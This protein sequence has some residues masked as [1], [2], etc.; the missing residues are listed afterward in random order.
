M[1]SEDKKL[2]EGIF[3]GIKNVINEINNFFDDAKKYQQQFDAIKHTG[4]GKKSEEELDLMLQICNGINKQAKSKYMKKL[5]EKFMVELEMQK[6]EAQG[7]L[8]EG[9]TGPTQLKKINKTIR[10]IAFIC[11][12]VLW[13]AFNATIAFVVVIIFAVCAGIYVSKIEAKNKR[14][15]EE[16]QTDIKDLITVAGVGQVETVKLL[17][18]KG[19]DIEA[20]SNDGLTALICAA[21]AGQVE[22]VKLL[23]DRGADIEAKNNDGL[24]VLMCAASMGQT[25]TVELLLNKGADIEAKNKDKANATALICA[26]AMGQTETVKLL[27]NK[28][29]EI[30]ANALMAAASNGQTKTVELLLNKGVDIE[31][32]NNDGWTALMFAISEGH[33]ETVALLLDKGA[34]TNIITSEG[35][36][37]LSMAEGKGFAKITTLLKKAGSKPFEDINKPKTIEDVCEGSTDFYK[38]VEPFLNLSII[39]DNKTHPEED[40]IKEIDAESQ[41]V[42]YVKKEILDDIPKLDQIHTQQ[43]LSLKEIDNALIKALQMLGGS[44]KKKVVEQKVYD[45]LQESFRN[46]WYQEESTPGIQRWKH[47]VDWAR[48]RARE[49]GFIKSTDELG[50]GYWGLTESGMKKSFQ[51]SDNESISQRSISQKYSSRDEIETEDEDMTGEKKGTRATYS[52]WSEFEKAQREKDERKKANLPIAKK[53]HDLIIDVLRK[54]NRKYDIRYGDGTFSFSMPKDEAKTGKRTFAR[55]G[56]VDLAGDN[57]YLDTLYKKED[58]AIPLGG[59]SWSKKDQNKYQFTMSTLEDFEKVKDSIKGGVIRS[60]NY[61]AKSKV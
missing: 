16:R 54:E 4:T 50:Q 51:G 25:E 6:D 42:P 27:I 20:K 36:T 39:N 5:T 7:Q 29:A 41:K 49:R 23:I 10:I 43:K 52:N 55:L 18:D 45:M 40:E 8:K 22:T 32:K 35:E 48:N 26:A 44:A 33:T 2:D 30:G 21:G 14:I 9:M 15:R 3:S 47:Q 19:A 13:I 12:F 37:A 11:F 38:K 46:P 57:I 24:T 53:I 17:I 59:S 60:Y 31:A 61:L 58:E 1:V 28:G 34:D 56:L